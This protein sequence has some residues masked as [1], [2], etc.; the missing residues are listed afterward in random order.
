VAIALSEANKAKMPMMRAKGG[1]IEGSKADMAQDNAL[2]KK[3]T[4]QHDAMKKADGGAV[5]RGNRMQAEEA[6]EDRVMTRRAPPASEPDYSRLKNFS[7]PDTAQKPTELSV[8]LTKRGPAGARYNDTPLLDRVVETARGALGLKK[9]G[10][11]KSY[12]ATKA[13]AGKDIG[14]PGKQFG[15]IAAKAAEEYGSEEAGKRVAGAVLN[16]LR[17]KAGGGL[18]AMPR[19]K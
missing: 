16:K 15:K 5:A 11:A 12:S 9:G 10:M 18:A 14:K 19:K 2:L 17:N 6:G 3:A 13:A 1:K 8:R 4:R 7:G